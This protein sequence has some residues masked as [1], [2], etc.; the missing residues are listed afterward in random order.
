MS[1][2]VTETTLNIAVNDSIQYS[3]STNTPTLT[4]GNSGGSKVIE[5]LKLT[6]H[7][8]SISMVQQ[9]PSFLIDNELLLSGMMTFRG[10][11]FCVST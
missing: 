8:L 4:E 3:I 2:C 6:R 9:T 1:F 7:L 11:K 10:A 5:K